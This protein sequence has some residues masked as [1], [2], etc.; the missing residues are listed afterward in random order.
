MWKNLLQKRMPL[1][2]GRVKPGH[3]W[4]WVG[5]QGAPMNVTNIISYSM[6]TI[7]RF[8]TLYS[9][10]L[11]EIGY[12]D[13]IFEKP[14]RISGYHY[15]CLEQVLSPDSYK[16]LVLKPSYNWRGFQEIILP[17]ELGN[18]KCS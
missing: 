13:T 12:L 8:L 11:V 14:I 3:L 2:D 16:P 4:A 9:T 6:K 5:K 17:R 15:S 10:D 7:R 18:L 1:P